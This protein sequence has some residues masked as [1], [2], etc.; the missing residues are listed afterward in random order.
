MSDPADLWKWTLSKLADPNQDFVRWRDTRDQ[1]FTY[2]DKEGAEEAAK[3]WGKMKNNPKMT[4]ENMSRSLRYCKV[5]IE[6]VNNF[7]N[8]HHY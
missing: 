6:K 3:E 8:F 4:Y 2:G 7:I 5:A 1:S